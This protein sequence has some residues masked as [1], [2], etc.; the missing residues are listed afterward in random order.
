MEI[1]ALL[2][3]HAQVAGKL[4]I[5][6]GSIN[7]FT[8]PA[9]ATEPFLITFALAGVVEVPW[10]ATNQEHTLRFLVLTE[11]G[12]SPELAG[13]TEVGP[14]GVGGAMQFTVGRPAGLP[15][16]DD[17]LVPFA[18]TVTALPLARTGKYVLALE[19]DGAH[20]KN[21]RF[22]VQQPRARVT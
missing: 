5:S 8:F 4:F 19:L 3:D 7:A 12:G 18:F 11:D 16:G 14:D 13:G 15:E 17:Q 21:L 9:D 22:R 10:T 1:N 2:C 20:V 6:G